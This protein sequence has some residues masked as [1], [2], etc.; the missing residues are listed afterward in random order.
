MKLGFRKEQPTQWFE[1]S[2]DSGYWDGPYVIL[3]I[4]YYLKLRLNGGVWDLEEREKAH[5]ILNEQYNIT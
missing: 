2:D 5:A 4:M 3:Y 1:N